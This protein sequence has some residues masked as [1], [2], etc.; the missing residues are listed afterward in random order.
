MH[1]GMKKRTDQ[2]QE[3]VD[4]IRATHAGASVESIKA[5]IAV[6][7]KEVLYGAALSDDNLTKWAEAIRD[8]RPVGVDIQ[9]RVE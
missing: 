6:A 4:A 1:N 5:L 9:T 8:G 3:R 2:L 7:F